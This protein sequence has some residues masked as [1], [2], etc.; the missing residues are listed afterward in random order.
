[1]K[2]TI[3]IRPVLKK[4]NIL[5]LILGMIVS[6]IQAGI[7][8]VHA[9]GNVT[10]NISFESQIVNGVGSSQTLEN[11]QSGEPFFLALRYTVNSGGDNVRY[12][13]C[14]ITIQLPRY[15]KF[16]ELAMVGQANSIFDSATVEDK[17][18][19][20]TEFVYLTSKGTL[21]SGTAGTI[22]LK[23]HFEN[24]KTPDGTLASFNNMIMTG[25]QLVGSVSTPINDIKIPNATIISTAHQEWEVQKTVAKQENQDVSIIK[26]EGKDYYK[27][28]YQILV[29]PGSE[30]T[31]GNRYGRL[32]CEKFDLYDSLPVGYPTGGGAQQISIAV[33]NRTLSE[34][35]DYTL[36]KNDDGSIKTIHF[37]ESSLNKYQT[38]ATDTNFI[39]EGTPI[40]TTYTV[41]VLYPYAAYEIPAN[42]PFIQKILDNQATLLYKPL[43]KNEQTLK[44]NAAV[45]VGWQNENPAYYDLTVTKKVRVNTT[46]TPSVPVEETNVMTK[47]WQDIYYVHDEAPVTFGLYTDPKC[48][49]PAS[50]F[51]KEQLINKQ[52]DEHGQVV[53]TKL[54]KGI[55]YLKEESAPSL[56]DAQPIRKVVVQE[57]GAITVDDTLLN[58]KA[59]EVV[60]TSSQY[61][62]VAFWKRGSNATQQDTGWLQGVGFTLTNKKDPSKT[63]QAVSNAQGLV[64]F[65]GIPEDDYVIN[66]NNDDAE[67][68]ENNTTWEIHV[69]ANQVNYPASMDKF[70]GQYPYVLNVSNKG[71][72]KIIKKDAQSASTLLSGAEFKIYELQNKD[73][74]LTDEEL[75]NFD[76]KD[77]VSHDLKESAVKGEYESGA[78][79]E[80]YYV[81]QETKAP[82][83]YVLDD[84]FFLVHVTK[85]HLEEI[86]IT[87]E[88]QGSLMVRKFGVL[89]SSVQFAVPIDGA[90]FEVYMDQAL[91][92]PVLDADNQPVVITPKIDVSDAQG[93][94]SNIVYLDPGQ[95][96]LKETKTPEG[97]Q[98]LTEAISV[99]VESGQ[100]TA[101]NINNKAESLGQL[102]ITKTDSK[103]NAPLANAEFKII[104][105]S[106]DQEIMMTLKTNSLGEAVSIFLPAGDYELLESKA[107]SGYVLNTEP[108]SFTIT[109]NTLTEIKDEIKNDPYIKFRIKKID[110]ITGNIISGVKFKIYENKDDLSKFISSSTGPKG[111]ATFSNIIPGKT[112]W[113]QEVSVPNGYVLDSDLHEFVAPSAMDT[114]DNLLVIEEKSVVV[115]NEPKGKFF[116]EKQRTTFQEG[117]DGTTTLE[118]LSISFSYY[119]KLSTDYA[120]DKATANANKTLKNVQTGP[121]GMASSILLEKGDYWVEENN[122]NGLYETLAPQV[123]HV[124]AGKTEKTDS[125]TLKLVNTY[126]KGR[127]RI[128]KVDANTQ[129]PVNAAFVLY[130]YKDGV[131]ISSVTKD[132]IASFAEKVTEFSTS[133][134]GI[135][136]SSGYKPGQYAI[137]E[138]SVTGNYALSDQV[139]NFAIQKGVINLD[140]FDTPIQNVPMGSLELVKNEVWGSGSSQV[141]LP[142]YGFSFNVYAAKLATA[143]TPGA[144]SCNGQYYVK[145]GNSIATLTSGKKTTISDLN[146]GFYYIEEVLSADQIKDYEQQSPQVVELTAGKNAV[147]TFHNVSKKARIKVDK[148]DAADSSKHLNNAK[149]DIYQ[150]ADNQDFTQVKDDEQ[151]IVV[152]GVKYKVVSSKL[153]YQIISGTAVLVNADGNIVNG[154]TEDGIGYSGLLEPNTTYFLKEVQAPDGYK[155]SKEWTK[156]QTG[157]AGTLAAVTIENF[158][159]IS[160]TG[161]KVDGAGQSVNGA[162]LA[163]LDNEEKAKAVADM[164]EA[165]LA[166]LVNDPLQQQLHGIIA[167]SETKNGVIDFGEVAKKT[168]YIVELKA[169]K[170]YLRDTSIHTVTVQQEADGSYHYYEGDHILKVVN[171]KY[172]RIWI[173]KQLKFAD[174]TEA[175]NGVNFNIYKMIEQVAEGTEGA[176]KGN[177]GNYYSVEL[178]SKVQTGTQVAAGE[179]IA[180]T[181]QLEPGSYLVVEDYTSLPSN[182]G[183]VIPDEIIGHV[184]T[185]S[186]MTGDGKDNLVLSNNPIVNE[187]DYGKFT[188][189]K[190]AYTDKTLKLKAVFKLYVQDATGN[191]VE[192]KDENG[193]TLT[194]DTNKNIYQSP[195]LLKSGQYR[196]VEQ[197]VENGYTADENNSF[198][199][200]IQS[201]KITGSSYNA[202]TGKYE[203]KYYSTMQEALD[204]PIT[205][206]NMEQGRLTL[207]KVGRQ[208]MDLTIKETPIEGAEFNLYHYVING[209]TLQLDE[210]TQAGTAISQSD[211][212]LA[213]YR[214]DGSKI[215]ADEN[216]LDAGDYVL[217]E[218]KVT[219]DSIANG[220]QADYLGLVRIVSNQETKTVTP[221]NEQGQSVGNVADKIVNESHY[222]QFSITKVDESDPTIKLKDVEFEIYKKL[223]DKTYS[224]LQ[225]T[226]TTDA[227]GIAVS[228]L[229]PEGEYCLK[230]T[231][232]PK[233]YFSDDNMHGPY[234]VDAQKVNEASYYQ[235]KNKKK[236]SVQI[237]K[238]DRKTN[239]LISDKQM[240]GTQFNLY[241]GEELVATATYQT[242]TG[243]YFENLLPNT[244]YQ[245]QEVKAPNGYVLDENKITFTTNSDGITKEIEVLNDPYG[246]LILDKVAAWTNS[247]DKL[248]LQGAEF[249]LY[250][251]TGTEVAKEVSDE[252]GK[253]Q[254]LNLVAGT[255]T[256]KET[257]TVDGFAENE[258]VYSITIVMG[259]ENTELTGSQAIVNNPNFGKFEFKKAKPDG[260]GLAGAIFSLYKEDKLI[261]D[262]IITKEDG[263]FSSFMLEPG[264]YRLIET[265][266]PDGFEKIEPITFEIK[267]T[268]ITA[269]HS[270][271]SDN[272]IDQALGQIEITKLD[273]V[274]SYIP[275]LTNQ[276][277]SGVHFGLYLPDGSLVKEKV[278]DADGKI[279]WTDVP[280][281]Q[282]YVQE[283]DSPDNPDGYV[284]SNTQ[285]QV[286]VEAQKS[287]V[288]TYYPNGT[289]HGEIINKADKGRLV[290]YKVDQTLPDKGLSGAVFRI[291]SDSAYT[292]AIGEVTTNELGYAVSEL[293]NAEADG[294]TYYV[295][296]IKAPEGYVLDETLNPTTASIKVYPIHQTDVIKEETTDKNKVMF[297]NISEKEL[298]DFNLEIHK[299]ITSGDLKSVTADQSLSLNPYEN[300]FIIRN[301]ANGTNK[302][303]AESIEITDTQTELQ[304]YDASQGKYIKDSHVDQ[305]SYCINSVAIYRAYNK[306]STMAVN[307]K[308]YYQTY[309]SD[310]WKEVPYGE[311]K[312]LQKLNQGQSRTAAIDPSLKAAHVKVVYTGI[313]KG[314][315]S[316]GFD[317]HYTFNQRPSDAAYNEI[318]RIQNVADAQYHFIIKDENGA[319]QRHTVTRESETVEILLPALETKVPT[320]NLGVV[321]ENPNGNSKTFKPGDMV[322]YTITA[323]NVST[324]GADFNQPVISFDLPV[325]MTLNDTAVSGSPNQF[326]ITKM[327][328]DGKNG[329]DIEL[330]KIEVIFSSVE[331]ARIPGADGLESLSQPTTKVTFRFKNYGDKADLKPGESLK[332]SFSGTISYSQPSSQ[333][334]PLWVLAYLNSDEKIVKSAENPYGNSFSVNNPDQNSNALVEDETL[335]KA[336]GEDVGGN[337]HANA[338]ADIQVN[339][340]NTL[341]IYKQVKGD[342]DDDYVD[343]NRVAQTSSGGNIDYKINVKN[344]DDSDTPVDRIRIVDIL[345]FYGDTLTSRDNDSALVF[346]RS[347]TLKKEALLKSIDFLDIPDYASAKIF[348]CID[349]RSYDEK[350]AKWTKEARQKVTT[351]EDL[352]ILY[353]T[354]S[355]AEWQKGVHK[356]YTADEITDDDLK[357]V[358]AVAVEVSCDNGQYFEK[359]ESLSIGIQM[360]AP[361]YSADELDKFDNEYIANSAM[362]AVSRGGLRDEP[363]TSNNRTE[364]YEVKVKL[365][366][367]KGKIGDYAFYDINRNGL[368]DD[369]DAPIAGLGVKLY[370]YKTTY[371]NGIAKTVRSLINTTTT[372]S[373]GYYEFDD[374]DCNVPV[375]GASKNSADPN[376]FAGKTIYEYQ[377]EF[378]RPQDESRYQY[379]PTLP[380]VGEDDSLDSDIGNDA[381]NPD[382]YLLTSIVR[383]TATKE[384][385]N[386]VG[387]INNSLDAGFTALGALGNYVWVDAN[388]NGIQDEDEKGINGVIVRVYHAND[389]GSLGSL[390]EETK[391]TFGYGNKEGYYTFKDLPEGKYIVEFDTSQVVT[392]GYNAHYSFTVPYQGDSEYD[393]NAVHSVNDFTMRSD[394]IQLDYRGYDMS[395][396]AGLTVYSAISGIAFEDRNYNDQQDLDN[397]NDIPVP[398]TLVELY[399]INP[400]DGTL[401]TTPTATQVVKEDGRYYFDHLTDG[402]YQVHFVFPD[403]YEIVNAN[404]GWDDS[405]DSD[406]EYNL[407]A[408]LRSGFTDIIPL[409]QNTL[410]EHIDG[411]A[412]RYSSLGDYVWFDANQ[413]GLQD[414]AKEEYG[415]ANVPVYLQM[416]SPNSVGWEQVAQ[417]TTDQS[418]HYLFEHLKASD[419]GTEIVYRIVFDLPISSKLT[420]PKNGDSER[421]SNALAAYLPGAGFPTDIIHLNYHAKD[422]SW[423]A[424]IIDSYGTIGDYVW[425]D[426][427]QNGLQDE[428]NSGI[429]GIPVILEYN[430]TGDLSD[431]R[432][433]QVIGQ[434]TT[435]AAGYYLFTDLNA[436][437]YR[438]RFQIERPYYVTLSN[439]GRD[440]TIDSDGVALFEDNWYYS[441]PFY[442]NEEGYDMRWDCGVYLPKSFM[443]DLGGFNNPDTKDPT[444][445]M[446]WSL[447]GLVSAG[448]VSGMVLETKKK[449]RKLKKVK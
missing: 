313:E 238:K 333:E 43:S 216:W 410:V 127:F 317:I 186:Y 38:S 446:T 338:N 46:G 254:F 47:E 237:I 225:K 113:Y 244:T 306:D 50:N 153:S 119:P 230:E 95:Y 290:I 167:I 438:V 311:F 30:T 414:T 142:A 261:S 241:L 170:N 51:D 330:D 392:G 188:L 15:V 408:D 161:E 345:P 248:P 77:L 360:Q 206:V 401:E 94:S 117:N 445:F 99:T 166:A 67:F 380:N 394:V 260:T 282:Y 109:N 102:K 339:D 372:S 447:I 175:L 272:V 252:N 415:I 413:N 31:S 271:G 149:F 132:N 335:D 118:P 381:N 263:T 277:I 268:E 359:G 316:D 334:R 331:E 192:Y 202:V 124:E 29:R 17:F 155:A 442:L 435:N 72:F 59:I 383:L 318:R 85:N 280:A 251:A 75:K 314:F 329:V 430:E 63:Y 201:N 103:T 423:D 367:P 151:I 286:T 386:Y 1:M 433:W 13:E 152:D 210:S 23:M 208:L 144:V 6:L 253:V 130:R 375:N 326:K 299:G 391:T 19:D 55:Y 303:K 312:D 276:P 56:F 416:R 129:E 221:I 294:T 138:K 432:F 147:A 249:T 291:Y 214:L 449:T 325:G 399:R 300:V 236:Q 363:I 33:G 350:W 173:K 106:D 310:T 342:F 376:D 108:V 348:Y 353:S 180:I 10:A 402:Q 178:I 266:A 308:V 123:V 42:E 267:A 174:Q 76:P 190:T 365:S 240:E 215:N 389:N 172:Q 86:T 393:S 7:P 133:N 96:Y 328:A 431:D 343:Y 284:Y 187:T 125:N 407:S 441:R 301:F 356:W 246:S 120:A 396:D 97:Y 247:T 207:N 197:S 92:Q 60:N 304:Y 218:T 90:E 234:R 37:N 265:T 70:D 122:A 176:I 289:T 354:M 428:T 74:P 274:S 226:I 292:N 305:D 409:P 16:D 32:D 437:M 203:A 54:L 419:Y 14:G 373:S 285:Y 211:G 397:G 137:I 27:V 351:T 9:A 378:E 323:Q 115:E 28:N 443:N 39:P 26:Q 217:K 422:L 185:L 361:V 171:N 98:K 357:Y 212:T 22:Y 141:T 368:Q 434:T 157:S 199:F 332:I 2:E 398:N 364:N 355:D 406:I 40:N 128:K 58:D 80:G 134:N 105:K 371:V 184:V 220:Y 49:S 100:L 213:F 78:L 321:A 81:V 324:N 231:N 112:Y 340:N 369:G 344:G 91:S 79:E 71:K 232:T 223:D 327:S 307:A 349:S 182:S 83:H 20:G 287:A 390:I 222:G 205:I 256:L 400:L 279:I 156:V 239:S 209:G 388:R 73:Q 21:S 64:L 25:N 243:I 270:D 68:V 169:P 65:S 44:S 258:N 379:I 69:A 195:I 18:G 259:E 403:E 382:T 87:N 395:V 154:A 57:D 235:I 135:Y 179:G 35:S 121:N 159:P 5:V 440:S 405:Q 62:Y 36:D 52:I 110:S 404:I 296:E 322:Q 82:L 427:N 164:S 194:I 198:D 302:V 114:D 418:G 346:D 148:V 200:E 425:F 8:S 158:K 224:S 436:G 250:N 295:K 227:Q 45:Q 374:L 262:T 309:G 66:E 275:G 101:E 298:M 168:Y 297:K 111:F 337:K 41:S 315:I 204:H 366:M 160:P 273:D 104:R 242:D 387:E 131:D 362:V 352:P 150:L 219:A 229:L 53:F 444:S 181:E 12:N 341:Y 420:I 165:E 162:I 264:Q 193:K 89:S 177:D 24:L 3:K 319:E 139:Y 233:G 126:A 107:P 84:Q 116:L 347:T 61:G 163:L 257:K 88:K 4:L 143:S 293:L 146:P 358:S 269:L 278:T 336:L 136:E 426:E 189:M 384:G 411:G 417:A 320:V 281:G 228:P 421:D 11:I 283:I 34:G 288:E 245:L 93:S 183:I 48:T 140:Y 145:D 424:G 448:I 439:V 385:T 255:Y 377:V 191:Y 429:G 196:L 412:S 370:Q